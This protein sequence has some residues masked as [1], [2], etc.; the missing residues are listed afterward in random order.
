MPRSS[1][2]SDRG[3]IERILRSLPAILSGD[4]ADV[5]G[6]R[7]RFHDA[8]LYHVQ[9][10]IH[11]SYLA[12]STGGA[13]AYGQSWKPLAPSSL[14]TKSRQAKPEARLKHWQ[15]TFSRVSAALLS[16]GWDSARATAQARLI[17]YR[18]LAAATPTAI[19]IRTQR[20]EQSF[21]PVGF[22]AAPDHVVER[23]GN[24]L[25]TG[26]SVPYAG[27]FAAKRPIMPEGEVAAKLVQDA[28]LLAV[29]EFADELGRRL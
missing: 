15:D 23:R 20:L 4:A 3:R 27:Y 7:E 5:N 8:L 24:A 18:S 1:S 25:V 6:L 17:A 21:T 26:S 13:D 10:L 2:T 12:R 9:D 29:E 19:G 22:R 28:L 14:R 16:R 11:R